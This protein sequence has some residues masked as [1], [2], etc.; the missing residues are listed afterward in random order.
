[1]KFRSTQKSTLRPY[2][3][4]TVIFVILVSCIAC[5]SRSIVEA[6]AE[7]EPEEVEIAWPYE[8]GKVLIGIASAHF[9]DL[10]AVL[11]LAGGVSDSTGITSL[12][13]YLERYGMYE[14][15]SILIAPD[16]TA[17]ARQLGL[18]RQ[19]RIKVN[20]TVDIE[21]LSFNL[22]NRTEIEWATPNFLHEFYVPHCGR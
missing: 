10:D 2:L 12:D 15:R 8:A 16:D 11:K 1:M 22:E 9:D 7:T 13:N 3:L 4:A 6:E 20:D 18:N 14:V 17:L 5:G 21:A 19:I